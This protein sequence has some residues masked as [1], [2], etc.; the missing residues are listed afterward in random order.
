VKWETFIF[1][2]GFGMLIAYV[3]WIRRHIIVSGEFI[4]SVSVLETDGLARGTLSCGQ[5]IPAGRPRIA[6]EI[7]SRFRRTEFYSVLHAKRTE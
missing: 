2:T 7:T 6:G 5:V 1:H 3:W 4:A